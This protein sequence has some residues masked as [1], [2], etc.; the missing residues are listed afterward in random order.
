MPDSATVGMSG[1]DAIRFRLVT[2]SALILP[3]LASGSDDSIG[4]AISWI[5]AAH[6]VGQRRRGA[7]VGNHQRIDAGIALEQFDGQ[8]AGRAEA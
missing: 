6:Q 3:A 5:C 2:A 4:S 7:L 1:A 8:M